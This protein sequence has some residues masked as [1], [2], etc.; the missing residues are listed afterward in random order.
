MKCSI[1]SIQGLCSKSQGFVKINSCVIFH[2]YVPISIHQDVVEF[3]ETGTER[4]CKS[5]FE[6]RAVFQE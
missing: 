1:Q 4:I 5:G 3:N 6:V 2:S